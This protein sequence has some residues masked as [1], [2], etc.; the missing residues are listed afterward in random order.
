M[1][2]AAMR[3]LAC[4]AAMAVV[5]CDTTR[6][7]A[8]EAGSDEGRIL[9]MIPVGVAHYRP[10]G[11]YGGGYDG[12]IGSGARRRIA[13]DLAR[14]HHLQILSEWPMPS[15]E[16][17][18]FLMALAPDRR[19]APVLQAIS[20]DTR[21]AW[22]QP[23]SVYRA[24]GHGDPL[25]PLQPAASS[26]HLSEVHEFT[27]GRGVTVAVIDSGVQLDH[28]DLL[29]RISDSRNFVEFGAYRAE[30]HGTAVAGLIA[31]NADDGIGIVG[32]AP[33]ARL[34]A[35][36][37]CWEVRMDQTEC[38]GFTLAKAL[39]FAL[40][41]HAQI[42]NLSLSGPDDVL[43]ARLLDLAQA[44]GVAVVA[45]ADPDRADGGFPA[46]HVGVIAV[47]SDADRHDVASVVAPGRDVPATLPGAGWG[48]VS[49][50]SF[51]AAQ[52]SGAVALLRQLNP[53]LTPAQ[54]RQSLL[55]SGD[56]GRTQ[57]LSAG[58]QAIGTDLCL[59]LARAAHRCA[60]ACT[61]GPG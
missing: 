26:W 42:V 24:L 49:G 55:D 29:G 25:F 2:R 15:L 52:V 17:D 4:L 3:L 23:L 47:S 51:A 56:P 39:Q 58:Q 14:A 27:T 8:P 19:V 50:S 54:A 40:Q 10:G 7:E 11:S 43:L 9:V 30:R 12:G 36:R 13:E 61:I 37:A 60:C 32:I 31:A 46:S 44:Q 53:A 45:A 22:A 20:L 59:V 48:F 41:N 33:Q 57:G 6:P 16:V 21:V 1:K 35:L 38:N 34:L 18:C 5:A 28:P